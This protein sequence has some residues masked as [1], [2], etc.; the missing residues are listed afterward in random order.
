M[1]KPELIRCTVAGDFILT[2]ESDLARELFNHGRYGSLQQKRIALSFF[3]AFYLFENERIFVV[4]GRGKELSHDVLLRKAQQKDKK[5]WTKYAV[6][7]D[8]RSRGYVV[9]TALKFG[10]DFRVYDRGVK[11]GDDHA[12]WVVYPVYESATMTWHE[13]SSKNRVAHST[14]KR[15]LLGVVDEEGDVSYWETRWLRP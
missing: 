12:K 5:F 6:F 1:V 9:K 15:L 3:E 2:E 10:A 11:P 14:K 13:F 8:L 7:R 4:D